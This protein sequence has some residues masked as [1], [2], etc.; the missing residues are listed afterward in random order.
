ML[1]SHGLPTG[2]FSNLSDSF[3]MVYILKSQTSTGY[4]PNSFGT[5]KISWYKR[6]VVGQRLK[7]WST[8]YSCNPTCISLTY[9][10]R[11]NMSCALFM[12]LHHIPTWARAYPTFAFALQ[13]S[14]LALRLINHFMC[15]VGV[16]AEIWA[17]QPIH[18]SLVGCLN[19][20]LQESS[21]RVGSPQPSG[22][23]VCTCKELALCLRRCG[24][25]SRSRIITSSGTK[26]MWA[27][28]VKLISFY[29]INNLL[30][31][32]YMR[33]MWTLPT[34]SNHPTDGCEH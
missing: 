28:K 19:P 31:L 5:S 10:R 8:N 11:F 16:V 26:A 2:C 29:T 23:C 32:R 6:K 4:V 27:L 12:C 33:L 3:V 14:G 1:W 21:V 24:S 22:R 17:N 34:L 13:M 15:W 7:E 20:C 9:E 25:E 30:A 18:L